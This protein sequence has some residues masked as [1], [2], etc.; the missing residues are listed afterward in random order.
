MGLEE[1]RTPDIAEAI[2]VTLMLARRTNP[3]VRCAG[4]SL[5]T[6]HLDP[7]TAQTVLAEH[8]TL[9]RMPVADPMRG[10]DELERL[11]EA[12]LT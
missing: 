12:C 11:V 9:L 10:G 6:A 4:V 2:E 1:F 7:A 3:S 8:A 5:N